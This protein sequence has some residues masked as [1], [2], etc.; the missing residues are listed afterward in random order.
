MGV[1]CWNAAIMRGVLPYIPL[2]LSHS[3]S[4]LRQHLQHR[5][6]LESMTKKT[7]KTVIPRGL[8]RRRALWAACYI[9]FVV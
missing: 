6:M 7:K 2:C 4:R 3:P 8:A 1:S 5:V 9:S